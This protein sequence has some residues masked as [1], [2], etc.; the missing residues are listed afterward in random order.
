MQQNNNPQTTDYANAVYSEDDSFWVEN[1]DICPNCGEYK[2]Y[3]G[4]CEC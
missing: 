2:P 1:Q 3:D 4:E